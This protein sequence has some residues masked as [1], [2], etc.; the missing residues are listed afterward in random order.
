MP[1]RRP[2]NRRRSSKRSSKNDRLTERVDQLIDL[3]STQQR[4]VAPTVRDVPRTILSRR[5]VYTMEL[6]ANLSPI[7][8]STSDVK[9]AYFFTLSQ[10]D[11]PSFYI[12]IF[13]MYRIIQVQLDF[14]PQNVNTGSNVFYSV[15]DY[16]DAI[17]PTVLPALTAYSTLKTTEAGQI[18]S[19]TLNPRTIGAALNGGTTFTANS[20]PS[21]SLWISTASTTVAYYGLKYYW[22]GSANNSGTLQPIAKFVIQFKGTQAL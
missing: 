11:N 19:R 20:V 18:H 9:G 7:T 13:D 14:V 16:T 22:P 21:N 5:K 17:L 8:P 6:A 3:Q 12:G 15:I 4:G 2:N 10:I 1:N